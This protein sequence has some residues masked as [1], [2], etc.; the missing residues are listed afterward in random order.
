MTLSSTGVFDASAPWRLSEQVSLRD[1]GF[2]A[3]AYHLCNRRLVF[4][5]SRELVILV[6]SLDAYE[7]VDEA[8]ASTLPQ[9]LRDQYVK[10]L[11]SLASSEI[12][13]ER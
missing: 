1:V 7:N 12:I 13:H 10:A 11:S 9:A 2:G 6:R 4:L 5:K 3:F 8:I